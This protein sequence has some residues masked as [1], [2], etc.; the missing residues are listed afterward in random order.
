MTHILKAGVTA[1]TLILALAS[2]D[3]A[4]AQD[5]TIKVGGRVMIDYTIADI[6]GLEGNP[7]TDISASELRRGRMF[8]SGTYGEAIKYKFE[9]NKASGKSI[10]ATD[11]WIQFAPKN[12]KFK[13]KVGQ[14]KTHN[15]L[16]EETS[17]RF[18]STIERAAFT[19]A[20]GLNRRVGASVGASGDRYTFNAGIFGANLE[21]D[22]GADESK[23]YAARFTFNPV[24]TGE[25]IAHLGASWRHREKGDTESDLRYRQRPYTHVAPSRIV[26][27][28]RFA[29]SDDFY[30]FEGAVIHKNL[31]AAGE[32]AMLDAK[33]TD[34]NPDA[35]FSGYY[36]EVG[37]I[38]GGKRTY[39]GGKFNRSKV[40][41]PLGEG[42]MG[43][44]AVTARYDSLDLE[45]GPYTGQL[46]TIILGATWMPTKQTRLRLDYFDSDAKGGTADKGQGVVARLGFDF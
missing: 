16:D 30:G 6:D 14:F 10:E 4:A 41:N 20:F 38:F 33:G 11:A 43:A 45:D 29:D 1:S 37:V 18:I 22:G 23:A 26:D 34:G 7:D 32:Y 15:S 35:D 40:D 31:W 17:S 27:T 44:F 8:I 36:G 19:D 28:G 42:G 13:I 5:A 24:K 21:A 2:A 9:V 3:V 39:K 25:T 12:T 46:D